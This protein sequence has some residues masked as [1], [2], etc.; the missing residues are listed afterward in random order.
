MEAT[1]IYPLGGQANAKPMQFP[2]GSGVSVNM[3]PRDD[4]SAFDQLKALVDT[5]GE[6]L[7]DPD[8]RGMLAT[9]GIIKDQPFNP[10][11]ATRAMLEPIQEEVESGESVVI[12]WMALDS[13]RSARCGRKNI[14]ER[15]SATVCV[16]RAI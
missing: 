11:V 6:N 12:P 5:E 16:I 7:A 14:A 4:A 1:K 8:W 10:D 3:L 15:R 13:H 9:L 2:D